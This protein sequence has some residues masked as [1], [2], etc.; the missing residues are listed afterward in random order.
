MS[1]A[2]LE[3]YLIDFVV[4]Q[5]GYPEEMVEMDA[6]LEADLGIDS[7]KKAQLF[8]ELAEH[9]EVQITDVSELSLDD[10]PTLNHV[11]DFLQSNATASGSPAETSA[12]PAPA[13]SQPVNGHAANGHQNGAGTA[14]LTNGAALLTPAV[15][16]TPVAAP[17]PVAA[18]APAAEPAAGTGMD[19]AELEQYLISFVVEQTG[20]PEE[21]VELDADLEADLG[22]DSIK[23]A[24]LF[25]ELA[26]HF[27]IQMTDVSELSLDDF[28]T[29]N[30]VRE[31][32]QNN[33]TPSGGEAAATQPAVV[34]APAP[35]NG[36][37][38][39]AA[40]A[41]AVET[42]APAASV[43]TDSGSS[44][45]NEELEQFLINF[46]VEQTGYP[47]EMVELDADL[48][49]DLGID[50]IKKAQMFG[51]LSEQFE[52]QMDDVSEMSLDDYPT[53]RHVLG[54]LSGLPRR[55]TV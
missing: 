32:L 17:A 2:D 55:E 7:I 33:A 26:E 43:A 54:F 1:T 37:A 16:A 10:F 23:K 9:F 49:A 18:S 21:M 28:P 40:P 50:S 45:D 53:L 46:V 25:G 20:Y 30:H 34:A 11:R 48:E 35:T 19:T 13:A 38:L 47:E 31:F 22:I 51:E 15:A 29:L 44:M 8:G 14:P 12:A 6:D 52:I 41:V 42:P 39:P 36:S 5:T 3:K 4:E 24:Q 27:E